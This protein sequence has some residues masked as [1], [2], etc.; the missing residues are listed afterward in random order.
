MKVKK[1]ARHNAKI[2]LKK[3]GL[4]KYIQLLQKYSDKQFV[5]LLSILQDTKLMPI[6]KI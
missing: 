3:L 6:M 4:L 2:T 1:T 5:T